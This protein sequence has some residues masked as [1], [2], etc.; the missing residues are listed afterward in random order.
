MIQ[1]QLTIPIDISTFCD[2][3]AN[4]Y[5]V[6]NISVIWLQDKIMCVNET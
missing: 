5:N 6:I 3:K 1:T 4:Y 2:G